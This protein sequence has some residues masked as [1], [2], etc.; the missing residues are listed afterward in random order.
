MSNYFFVGHTRVDISFPDDE[1]CRVK[2]PISETGTISLLPSAYL[3]GADA[4][5]WAELV[6]IARANPS[7]PLPKEFF[8]LAAR[9]IELGHPIR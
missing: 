2:F 5:A 4:S 9:G 6:S 1:D 3:R 7:L 8:T